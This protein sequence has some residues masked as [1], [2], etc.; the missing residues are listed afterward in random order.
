MEVPAWG[1]PAWE[2]MLLPSRVDLH[3]AHGCRRT[4]GQVNP[5]QTKH[6]FILI[7]SSSPGNSVGSDGLGSAIWTGCTP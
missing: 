7:T 1:W 2:W 4:P 3:A 5:L 6:V